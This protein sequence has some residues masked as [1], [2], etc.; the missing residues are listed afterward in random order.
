MAAKTIGIIS[1]KGG[2]G[3]TSTVSAL[4]A[5]LAQNFGKKVLA[6]DANFSAPNL[7]LH[8]GILDP[9]ITLHHV[10]SGK[11]DIGEAV[12]ETPHGFHFIPGTLFPKKVNPLK[13]AE[14]LKSLKRY[15]DIILIDSSPTLNNE[16]LATMMASD[17]LFVV[18]TPD[19]VT[20]STTLNAVRL[21]KQRKTPIKGI[22]LNRVY[23]KDFELKIEDIE[24]AANCNV[25]AVLPHDVDVLRALSETTPS[26][27]YHNNEIAKEYRELAG[28]LIGET[29]LEKGFSNKFKTFFGNL[30]GKSSKQDINRKLLIS[31]L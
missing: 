25:V 15:Y 27:L 2:V 21:A 20:L 26:T 23:N 12:Y 28:A 19:H 6:V 18:T 8:F 24:A 22:I 13:L 7:G 1:I 30:F 14:K 31:E 4:A 10:L 3:K 17:E 9:E 11:A 5:S 16:I 29:Y